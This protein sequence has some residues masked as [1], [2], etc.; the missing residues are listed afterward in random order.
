MDISLPQNIEK[1]LRNKVAEGIFKTMDDAVLFAIQLAFVDDTIS[2]ERIAQLNAEIEKGWQDME[3]GKG[4]PCEEVFRD[5][6][7]KYA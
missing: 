7:K 4:R 6:R 2:P 5:L 1:I 3:A